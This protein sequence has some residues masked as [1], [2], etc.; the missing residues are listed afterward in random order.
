[1]L[2]TQARAI[3]SFSGTR[4][5]SAA[6]YFLLT[7]AAAGVAE[8][9]APTVE[10]V[11]W[12]NKEKVSVVNGALT[13]SAGQQGESQEWN[14]GASSA[15]KIESGDG[16]VEFT[17]G[18]QTNTWRMCGLSHAD[19]N[20]DYKTIDYAIYTRGDG[21]IHIFERGVRVA[22]FPELYAPDEKLRV[23]AEGGR[24]KYYRGETL[25]YTSRVLVTG[26]SMG[27]EVTML[28]GA[29]DHRISLAIPAGYSPDMNVMAFPHE[30][31]STFTLNHPCWQW[32]NADIREYVDAS[33]YFSL[34]S[35][36][37]LIIE[38]G[39]LDKTFSWR[40]FA[41]DK[42]VARR[43]RVAYSDAPSKF[44]HYLHNDEHRYRFGDLGGT[45][46]NVRV[47]EQIAPTTAFSTAWQSDSTTKE[48]DPAQTD[49][50][51]FGYM[52]CYLSGNC[53]I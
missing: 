31:H 32:L 47:P 23:A 41:P 15:Q 50:T 18:G 17:P 35:P 8:A 9:Q 51:L 45:E 28:V 2:P 40:A 10:P 1:M 49:R 26:L 12:T 14:A 46:L 38:T 21:T 19:A 20:Q 16:Y 5:L 29:L 43:L 27:G 25:I 39:K 36:R 13:R 44:I 22:T 4:A 53:G 30:T 34:V 11:D 37:P 33:D 7:F 42:Q 3:Q 52:Q 6:V 24:I 48:L